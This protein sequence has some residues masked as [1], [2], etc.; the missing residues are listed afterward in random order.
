[1]AKTDIKEQQKSAG[2]QV[3][4]KICANPAYLPVVR[5]IVRKVSEVI[6]LED[7]GDLITLA[8][9]EALANVIRHSY[10]GA[11][12]KPIVVKFNKINYGVEKKTALE[13]IIRDFGKQVE[14]ETIKGRD[15]DELRAGGLGVHII[16]SAM[17]E[18]EYLCADDCGMQLRMVKYIS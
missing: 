10:G 18:I 6:G 5:T 14:P 17:D 16:Q 7:K 2:T 8:V 12:D 1:M 15:L 3:E 4:L 11:C 13:I 9:E